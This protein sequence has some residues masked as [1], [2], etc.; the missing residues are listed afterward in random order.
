MSRHLLEGMLLEYS[1]P[2][3]TT[4]GSTR[5]EPLSNLERKLRLRWFALL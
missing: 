3:N 1:F 2:K 5:P 4:E